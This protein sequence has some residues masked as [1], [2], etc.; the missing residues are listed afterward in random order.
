MGGERCYQEFP[1]VITGIGAVLWVPGFN[2]S[3]R[4][5]LPS[6]FWPLTQC[7]PASRDQKQG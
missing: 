6:R 1:H 4:S 7:R 5:M 2:V 3:V